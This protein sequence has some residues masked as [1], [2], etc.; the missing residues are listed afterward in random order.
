M[1]SLALLLLVVCFFGVLVACVGLFWA[2][3][4]EMKPMEHVPVGHGMI[5]VYSTD[6]GLP[7]RSGTVVRY[8]RLLLPGVLYVHYLLSVYPARIVNLRVL[9]NRQVEIDVP[10]NGSDSGQTIH[11]G[12]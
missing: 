3:N 5:A 2:N 1:S 4:D 12:P 7:H 11:V 10:P 6:G 9:G 8:E